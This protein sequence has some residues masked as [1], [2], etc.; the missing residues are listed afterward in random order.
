MASAPTPKLH[1]QSQFLPR[2]VVGE[3]NCN[4]PDARC[5]DDDE[6]HP[7]DRSPL[8]RAERQPTGEPHGGAE[9]HPERADRFGRVTISG[10]GRHDGQDESDHHHRDREHDA[11]DDRRH[12][13]DA[14]QHD[15][16]THRTLHAQGIRRNLTIT[17]LPDPDVW[18]GVTPAR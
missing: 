10:E 12:T 8:H 17:D 9:L 7:A 15:L 6:Q 11:H 14:W 5:T 4:E 2:P 1:R 16:A 13:P 3:G 18:Y